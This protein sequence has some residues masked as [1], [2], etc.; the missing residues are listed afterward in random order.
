MSEKRQLDQ[1]AFETFAKLHPHE[2]A[3]LDWE[4]F[5]EVVREQNP[6]VIDLEVR[7]ALKETD[8]E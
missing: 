3:E 4:R 7:L 2:A 5:M 1:A 6:R 8:S